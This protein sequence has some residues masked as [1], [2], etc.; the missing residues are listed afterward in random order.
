MN[1]NPVVPEYLKKEISNFVSGVLEDGGLGRD[2]EKHLLDA[3]EAMN[4]GFDPT[5]VKGYLEEAKKAVYNMGD[6]YWLPQ[7]QATTGAL[8]TNYL[9]NLSWLP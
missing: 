9:L 7:Q 1:V 6:G 4:N 2:I 3:Q 5:K 8:L